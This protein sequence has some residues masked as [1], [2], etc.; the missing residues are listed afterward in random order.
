MK[1]QKHTSG[2]CKCFRKGKELPGGLGVPDRI[3]LE[4]KIIEIVIHILNDAIFIEVGRLFWVIGIDST[5][6]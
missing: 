3:I 6:P 4:G 1:H 2:K 5:N